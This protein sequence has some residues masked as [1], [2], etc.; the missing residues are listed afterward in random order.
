MYRYLPAF[1]FIY[2]MNICLSLYLFSHVFLFRFLLF[3]WVY[4]WTFSKKVVNFLRMPSGGWAQSPPF[5]LKKL[6][7]CLLDTIWD[8][9]SFVN[10][11]FL[12]KHYYLLFIFRD[13]KLWHEV[14]TS[15]FS[16]LGLA[17]WNS[18]Y[19]VVVANSLIKKIPTM[20]QLH[21]SHCARC[22]VVHKIQFSIFI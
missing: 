15:V 6:L 9:N 18:Y 8:E 1:E 14:G 13:T 5:L 11:I 7:Y 4:L 12:H 21:V 19:I 10:V 3:A 22:L 2:F 17:F 16:F 20:H